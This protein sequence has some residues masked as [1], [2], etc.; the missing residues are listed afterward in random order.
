LSGGLEELRGRVLGEERLWRL[1]LWLAAPLIVSAGLSSLNELA[2]TFWLSRLGSAALGTPTVS[3]PYRGI[4]MSISFGVASSAS[5]LIGQYVG[6]GRFEEAN[7][8]LATIAAVLFA[9]TVPGTVLLSLGIPFYLDATGVPPDIRPLAAVY[10]GV[11]VLSTPFTAA[12]MLYSFALSAAGDT[13]TPTK[14]SALA[15]VTNFL[16]DPLFIFPLG[17]GVLGAGLATAVAD[18]VSGGYALLDLARGRHGL[19]LRLARP[20]PS[21]LRLLLRVSAPMTGQ[22]LGMNLG[23]IAM[24]GIVNGL[25][26]PV[27]AAYA[28]GQVVL[29]IDRIIAFPVARA[30]GV[31]VA[32]SLGAG[33]RDRAL[34]AARTGLLLVVASVSAYIGLL[35]AAREEFISLFTSDPA[36]AEAAGRMLLIFGPSTMG[37]NLLIMANVI[38]RSSGH[39]LLV[40]L[41]GVARLWLLRIPL[42]YLLAYRLGM[43]DTGLWT[44]MA[45][46]NYATGAA[47]AAWI[48]HGGWARPVIDGAS[49]SRR[50]RARV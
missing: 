47:A 49:P 15:A 22:R 13:K 38:A 5:A 28:I 50:R 35:L 2:D 26:T 41:L 9:V 45:V 6:A 21:L 19:R 3:W 37:F 18:A 4:L 43:G 10:L 44:G 42:S 40:S 17:L 33:L 29:G 1:I 23:F 11:L 7:R 48:L 27:V 39:T 32:Q 46:S 34:K 8:A 25:G 36:V 20:D 24:T 31:V 14:I 30:T 16:L 12:F